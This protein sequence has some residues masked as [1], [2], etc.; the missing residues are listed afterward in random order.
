MGILITAH[1][2]CGSELSIS[3]SLRW[4]IFYH[5]NS[6]RLYKWHPRAFLLPHYR[7]S[8][9]HSISTLPLCANPNPLT[10]LQFFSLIGFLSRQL[11]LI[12]HSFF[13]P[14]FL[15]LTISFLFLQSVSSSGVFLSLL[16][17]PQSS[18][19]L[20]LWITVLIGALPPPEACWEIQGHVTGKLA[21]NEIDHF[22]TG[23][24]ITLL[25]CHWYS[26]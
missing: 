13:L 6:K 23:N 3:W 14:S 26:A 25:D 15:T 16:S 2:I 12:S 7:L 4:Y 5:F 1:R 19:S 11:S 21:P 17:H 18:L 8:L 22:L 24:A 10:I 9:L 20:S